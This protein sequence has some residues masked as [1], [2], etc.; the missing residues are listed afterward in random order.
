MGGVLRGLASRRLAIF[1]IYNPCQTEHGI[2]DS[3]SE[4]AAR[5]ALESRA[6][7]AVLYDP[8]AG[9]TLADRLDLDGNPAIEEKWPTFELSYQDEEGK[10][11]QMVLPMTI[12]DWAATEKRFAKHFAPIEKKASKE[13]EL[14]PYH[15]YLGLPHEERQEK[16]AFIYA[17]ESDKR[18]MR[19]LVSEEIVRLGEERLDLWSQLREM[20]GDV[21]CDTVQAK[22]ME[23]HEVEFEERLA[24]MRDEYESQIEKMKREYPVE[25]ARRMADALVTQGGSMKEVVNALATGPMVQVAGAVPGSNEPR[26]SVEAEQ[27]PAIQPGTNGPQAEVSIETS[28]KESQEEEEL[29][30]E[31]WIDEELCT[32]CGDCMKI[33]SKLFVF[34]ENRKATI[35][36]PSL[37][38]YADLVRAAE[39]C[40]SRA[41]H[42]GEPLNRKERNLDKWLERAAPFNEN[43]ASDE[44]ERESVFA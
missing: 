19:L 11:Q 13:K 1:N 44:L 12:A 9:A 41:I 26:V 14:V 43:A 7:P 35:T 25:V 37:G 32:A 29:G 40:P 36:D 42:P 22:V 31:P 3:A 39:L 16:Q 33:N 18:L 17:L 5:R 21:V 34:N 15:E 8:D 38:T 20:S 28:E 4:T 30:M 27:L 6:Y 10:E 24:R 23:D 2:V